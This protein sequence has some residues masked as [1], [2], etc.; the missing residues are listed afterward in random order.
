MKIAAISDIHS[1]AY[2]LKAVIAD[3]KRR[4]ADRMLNL[5]DIL[6]GPIAPRATF[7]ILTQHEFITI[8]GNQD[9]Q[10]YEATAEQIHS[11]PT[12]QF[13][14]ADLGSEPLDWMASLPF[15]IQLTEEIYLCHGTPGSDRT[16]LLENVAC[17]YARLRSDAEIIE[18]LNGKVSPLILCGHTH[19]QRTVQLMSGQLIVNP[20]S[21]G[22]PAYSDCEPCAHSMESHCAH[23]SYAMVEKRIEGWLVEQI[24]VPYD[25]ELA[26]KASKKRGRDDWAHFLTTGKGLVTHPSS[27]SHSPLNQERKFH[28]IAYCGL[29]CS[30]CPTFLATLADDDV[31][32]GK[33]SALYREKFGLD[34]KPEEINCDGCKSEVGRLIG[35]CQSCEIRR[36]CRDKGLDNCTHCADSP[37]EHLVRFH[38]FSPQ[39]KESFEALKPKMD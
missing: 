14:R 13:I 29:V 17:G 25:F 12:M 15:D 4:G 27:G 18:L 37:C 7:D 33:T 39:A 31:A 1:N 19:L 32:R 9:R 23:A 22:L 3:A 20:G 11:N 2:A 21:V 6:Y 28:M 36:C 8:C 34:L 10:I 26:V 24:K 30:S 16:Y 38:A 5:G 35:Y